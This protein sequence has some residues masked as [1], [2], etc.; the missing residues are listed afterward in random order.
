MKSRVGFIA[1]SAVVSLSSSVLADV[2]ELKTGQ[3]V[4][5]TFKEAT[6]SNVTIEVGGQ[7]IT[8]ERGR[9][10]AIHFGAAP[11]AAQA[12]E[13]QEAIKALA[14][15]RSV[16]TSGVGYREY[17]PR[18]LDAKVIVDRYLQT[19][20]IGDSEIKG[21]VRQAIQFYIFVSAAWNVYITK[22]DYAAIGAHP[23]LSDCPTALRAVTE[24][25]QRLNQRID[26]L[27]L[28]VFIQAGFPALWAC[29]ADKATAAERLIAGGSAGTA[30]PESA[31]PAGFTLRQADK[32]CVRQ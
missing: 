31:C 13:L 16:V 1:I 17:A 19:S 26:P 18:V 30:P 5:G 4:E 20:S 11:I 23:T 32:M 10:R 9:V 21:A 29:A 12:S 14:S 15:M 6:A 27:T 2:I 8:F 7:T 22:G 28:G 24:Y 3:R 25:A